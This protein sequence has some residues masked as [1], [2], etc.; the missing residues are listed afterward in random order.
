MANSYY[1]LGP[2]G[3]F[4]YEEG[5]TKVNDANDYSGAAVGGK[6][7]L[8]A[9]ATT[10]QLY[11]GEPPTNSTHVLRLE[12]SISGGDGTL[13]TDH[14]WKGET[15][16]MVAGETVAFGDVCYFKSDGKFW[17]ADASAEATASS[18]IVMATAAI[19]A[20]AVGVFLIRGLIRDDSWAWTVAAN[21]WVHTTGGNP[22]ETQPSGAGEI[23]RLV[24]Y[25]KGADY[26]WFSPDETWV[27]I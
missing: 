15:I 3:P 5:V 4:K 21:L 19:V 26:V 24:G 11:V 9:V 27:E 20:D 6:A 23:V 8:A 2:A 22:T 25:A 17:L 7:N 12:D 18:W 13:S 10:G 1:W 16:E 14:T